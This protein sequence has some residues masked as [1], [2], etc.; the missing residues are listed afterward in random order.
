M[1]WSYRPLIDVWL[2]WSWEQPGV[3]AFYI[4]VILV[5]RRLRQEAFRV[6]GY[7]ATIAKPRFNCPLPQKFIQWPKRY[8]ISC[9][10]GK[11]WNH[12]WALVC[13]TGSK[14][15]LKACG[16]HSSTWIPQSW[17]MS[18]LSL[19][20]TLKT[21]QLR[22]F[23]MLFSRNLFLL[24][25]VLRCDFIILCARCIHRWV[26][27]LACPWRGRRSPFECPHI[28]SLNLE[29]TDWLC[30]L[31]SKLQ[32]S[33]CFHYHLTNLAGVTDAKHHCT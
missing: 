9:L 23:T 3:V 21:L 29:F 4:P 22:G 28:H 26:H 33:F 18:L 30:Y 17:N 14:E 8:F 31:V 27:V 5:Y 19:S 13:K 7:P 10:I 12:V 20:D 16:G 2:K 15:I 32:G 1:S 6:W 24:D 11:D 25:W